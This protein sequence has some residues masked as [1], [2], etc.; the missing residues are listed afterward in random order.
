VDFLSRQIDLTQL[1]PGPYLIS[2]ATSD[3]LGEEFDHVP[4]EVEV[5]PKLTVTV[6]GEG[7]VFS[8]PAGVNS[9]IYCGSGVTNPIC[10]DW[11]D[12]RNGVTLTAVPS[13]SSVEFL[14][15]SGDCQGTDETITVFTPTAT[16]ESKSCTASFQ[17]GGFTYIY[18]GNP[19]TIVTSSG[20][21]RL[22][23]VSGSFT[24]SQPLPPN[25]NVLTNI[26]P[27]ITSLSFTAGSG[28]VGT[29]P[30]PGPA[31]IVINVET[32]SQ[33]NIIAWFINIDELVSGIGIDVVSRSA[34]FGPIPSPSEDGAVVCTETFD[35][36]GAPLA[37]TA[38]S[39]NAHE[40]GS[41]GVWTR[42]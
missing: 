3:V 42:R 29:I 16:P 14:G 11:F 10:S 22:S 1:D 36:N 34:T 25:L 19:F 2:V 33:S 18:T 15:W 12:I 6:N 20:L 31:G 27:L 38:P 5:P 24:V 39:S 13:S 28:F 23:N 41:P 7:T 30:A 35:K 37:C 26:A 40:I 8:T 32:D 17:V 21:G 4:V 9:G